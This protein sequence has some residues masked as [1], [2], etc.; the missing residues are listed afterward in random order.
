MTKISLTLLAATA[1]L[2]AAA[3]HA[4]PATYA[5]DPTHTFVTFEA[6]HFGTSTNRGRFDKKSGSI[7]LD[8][9]AKTG[10]VDVALETASINTGTAP[11]DNHLKSKDFFNVEAFPKATFTSDKV[12]FD[13]DKVSAVVGAFTLLGKTQTVTLKANNFNCYQ[14]PMLKR[15]VCG[16]DFDTT[17]Q[18]GDFGMTYGLP[19]IPNDIHLIIQIEAV[20]Q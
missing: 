13:G 17:I 14:N 3:V 15:E 4:E 5:I 19:G 20:K 2:A 12:I 16:G 18:R 10:K 9:A 1:A 11:F 6:K 8:V 7:T